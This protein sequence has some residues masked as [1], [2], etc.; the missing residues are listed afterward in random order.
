MFPEKH[1]LP[2]TQGSDSTQFSVLIVRDS[3]LRGIP[4]FC[5]P[6]KSFLVPLSQLNGTLEG[7]APL[8]QGPPMVPRPLTEV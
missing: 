8:V 7:W 6:I 1:F 4:E 3:G 5:S 2:L